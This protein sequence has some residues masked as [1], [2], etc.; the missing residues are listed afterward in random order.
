MGNSLSQL[1]MNVDG[2]MP[3][4]EGFGFLPGEPW[5]LSAANV[6]IF[7]RRWACWAAGK[8]VSLKPAFCQVG[9]LES[10]AICGYLWHMFFSDII[11]L[12]LVA[13]RPGG[14]HDVE[15]D[16]ANLRFV[17]QLQLVNAWTCLKMGD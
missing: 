7:L 5:D 11:W 3:S 15:A 16:W 14:V 1:P 9:C 8:G 13:H 6:R 10:N 2:G 12:M 4:D 17:S